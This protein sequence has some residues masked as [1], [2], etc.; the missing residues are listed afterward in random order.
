M[1]EYAI[2]T[3]K[4]ITELLQEHQELMQ[5]RL[6]LLDREVSP[7][8]SLTA[9]ELKAWW[10]AGLLADTAYVALII[11]LEGD[12]WK[13][14]KS[15]KFDEFILEWQAIAEDDEGNPTKVKTLKAKAIRDAIDK[16]VAAQMIETE[17]QLFLQLVW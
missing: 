10:I 6:Q 1:L 7:T 13:S 11:K 2:S 9:P 12:K 14:L 15:F 16:M 5:D 17:Q 8:I 4:S 3:L